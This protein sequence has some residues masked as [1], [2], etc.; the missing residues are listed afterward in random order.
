M[1]ASDPVRLGR[2]PLTVSRLGLG[3]AWL[4]N[5][6]RAVEERAAAAVLDRALELGIR[7]IDT[8]PYYGLGMAERR[9]GPLLAARPRDSFVLSTKVGRVLRPRAPGDPQLQDE[10]RP[11]FVDAPPLTPGF[12]F[13]YD[14]T[15]RS[16][17]ES[18]ERLGLDRVDMLL[19]HDP[20]DHFPEALDGAYRA[21]E[22][23]RAEGAV[24]AIGAGMNQAELLAELVRA[25]D[26]DVVLLAGRYTLLDQS[27][28]KELLP[29]CAER[30]VAVV[31][32]GVYNSGILADP[33]P[34]TLYNYRTATPEALDRARRIQALCERHGVPLKAAAIQFPFGHPAVASVLTGVRS[35]AELDDNAAML[36]VPVPA[37]LWEDLR[38]R[39]LLSADYQ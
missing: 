19:I 5:L 14:A 17:A 6:Y 37:E 9:I 27:G 3:T 34:G 21:L 28:L 12:D 2:T 13:S 4:G 33:S 38:A 18:L 29:L 22:R 25:A 7:L 31:I 26:P 24:A 15:L 39:R 36:E 20:D 11:L 23:L 8:A 32:G 1:R 30:N 16:V 10:G 35:V